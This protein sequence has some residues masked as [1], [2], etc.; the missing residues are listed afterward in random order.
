MFSDF[1]RIDRQILSALQKDARQSNKEL[2]AY[3]GLSQS[4]C[5]ERVRRLQRNGVLRGFHAEVEPKAMG[6]NL[7]AMI[8]V[9]LKKHSRKIVESFRNRMLSLPEVL[10]VYLVGGSH[11]FLIHVAVPDSNHLRNLNLD[12]ITIRSEV[13]AVETSLVFEHFSK[14]LFPY[15]EAE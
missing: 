6:V 15:F 8:M 5:L 1:D 13:E 7:Q 3:V 10:G 12:Q 11:D 14:H 2:A 4:S 9:R